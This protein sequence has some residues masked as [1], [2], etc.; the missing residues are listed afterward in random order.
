MATNYKKLVIKTGTAVITNENGLLNLEVMESLVKQITELKKKGIEV[1]FV[2]SGAMG[3]GRGEITL[4][5]KD[6]DVSKR[7]ILAAVGQI[8]LI[9]NYKKLFSKYG[10]SCAQVL[11]TKSDFRDRTH[12]LNMKNCFEALD[13]YDII[14]IVNENDV[15][16]VKELMFTD[17]DEL[18]GLISSMMNVDSLILLTSTDGVFDRDPGEKDAKVIPRVLPEEE[19]VCNISNKKSAFGRG[20]MMTKCDIAK[21]M[22]ALGI[23]T[24][25]VSGRRENSILRTVDGEEIG[26]IFISMQKKKIPSIKKWIA[27]S[28]GHEK[29]VIFIDDGA[30]RALIAKEKAVSLLPVGIT[31]FE[32]NFKENDIV[33]IKDSNGNIVGLGKA[34]YS[35]AKLEKVLGKKNEKD[36][37]HYDFLYL[38]L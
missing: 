13:K 26:T 25:I 7:Q 1:V 8:D 18:A 4:S 29:G 35:S 3:A 30:K 22:S 10:Y 17:N 31:K 12:Y 33:K 23:T 37:I 38:Y 14:P 19:V 2:S 20:G 36:F 11:V 27:N 34:E 32:G 28:L 6:D 21:K 24:H 9:N 16:S 15:V 5:G